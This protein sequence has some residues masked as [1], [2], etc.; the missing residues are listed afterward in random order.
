MLV[1]PAKG[2]VALSVRVPPV[3]VRQPNAARR[4]LAHP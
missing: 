4:G 1:S 3:K 2:V